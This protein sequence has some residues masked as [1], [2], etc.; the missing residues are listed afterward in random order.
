MLIGRLRDLKNNNMRKILIAILCLI[1]MNGYSQVIYKLYGLKCNTNGTLDSIKIK[2]LTDSLF[3]NNSFVQFSKEHFYGYYDPSYP[4]SFENYIQ[5]ADGVWINTNCLVNNATIIPTTVQTALDG[6]SST[7]HT[8]TSANITDGTT[9][10][11]NLFTLANPSA[12]TFPRI[13][14]DN[15]ITARTAAQ[16]RTDLSLVPGTDVLAPNGSAASLTNFPTLNQNTSGTAAGLSTPLSFANGGIGSGAATSATSGTMTVSMTTEMIT[17]TPTNACTFNASGGVTGQRVT[18]VITTSGVSSFT[19][20]WGTNYRT[21]GTLATGTTT[22]KIFCVTF[23]YN[24]SLW[25]ETN[26]TAAM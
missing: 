23:I 19:L 16:V 6:K 8:H 2:L 4:N 9:V 20:T 25:L 13:N 10:G 17:I 14:S 21:T 12:N 3:I 15:T 22:A 11:R 26:R 18:F 5:R 24:G 7:S 1:C